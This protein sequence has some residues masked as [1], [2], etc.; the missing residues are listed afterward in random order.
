MPNVFSQSFPQDRQWL[1][2]ISLWIFVHRVWAISP[3]LF[4][5]DLFSSLKNLSMCLWVPLLTL[6]TLWRDNVMSVW[7]S[8]GH[9]KT[10]M[11]YWKAPLPPPNLPL[12]NK[13][14]SFSHFPSLRTLPHSTSL[15]K[16]ETQ[17]TFSIALFFFFFAPP[18]PISNLATKLSALSK[19]IVSL[20]PY[21]SHSILQM[22]A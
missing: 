10:W 11:S 7:M 8:N 19:S 1:D 3:H 17:E 14:F 12:D 13:R 15:F 2:D 22:D 16:P 21:S 6:S 4:S 18:I 20:G 9:L 5:T